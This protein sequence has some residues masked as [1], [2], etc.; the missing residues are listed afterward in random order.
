MIN[1]LIWVPQKAEPE[2]K[3]HVLLFTRESSVSEK[4]SEAGRDGETE[5]RHGGLHRAVRPS[6]GIRHSPLLDSMGQ[7]SESSV[8][9]YQNSLSS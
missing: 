7:S 3:V 5:S 9:T 8:T 1:V 4:G 2:A 6:L